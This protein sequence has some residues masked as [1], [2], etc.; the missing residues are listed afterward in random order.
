MHFFKNLICN[1][2]ITQ[3]RNTMMLKIE[4]KKEKELFSLHYNETFLYLYYNNSAN[5]IVND[6]IKMGLLFVS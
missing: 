4:K 1:H 5:L 3:F 6:R 2:K